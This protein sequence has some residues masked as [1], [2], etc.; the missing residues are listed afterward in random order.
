[1]EVPKEQSSCRFVFMIVLY[2]YDLFCTHVNVVLHIVGSKDFYIVYND[3]VSKAGESSG[4]MAS[5]DLLLRQKG[6]D[7][8]P[9]A[10]EENP[11]SPTG[12]GS[13]YVKNL[14]LYSVSAYLT[15]IREIKWK[16]SSGHYLKSLVSHSLSFHLCCNSL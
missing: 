16:V 6:G 1:M 14:Y 12:S 9:I 15:S 7:P 13:G 11:P 3:F 5:E 4:P 2:V 8:A 10:S